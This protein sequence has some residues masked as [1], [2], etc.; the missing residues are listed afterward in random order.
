[1]GKFDCCHYYQI[2]HLHLVFSFISSQNNNNLHAQNFAIDESIVDHPYKQFQS[3]NALMITAST[4][5]VLC[6]VAIIGS[7]VWRKMVQ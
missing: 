4:L 2:Y 5:A 6:A 3:P 1:M 7:L